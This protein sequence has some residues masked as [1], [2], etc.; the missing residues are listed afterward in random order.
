[1]CI[2][3]RTPTVKRTSSL[4]FHVVRL[5]AEDGCHLPSEMALEGHVGSATTSILDVPAESY[6]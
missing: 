1:M 2:N 5:A 3:L 6:M 4:S